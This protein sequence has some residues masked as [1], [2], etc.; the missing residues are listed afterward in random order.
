[1]GNRLMVGH[2]PLEPSS[3][4]PRPIRLID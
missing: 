2:R 3:L 1:L 4:I